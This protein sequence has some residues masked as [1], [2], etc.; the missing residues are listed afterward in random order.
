M[1]SLKGTALSETDP[2]RQGREI[3]PSLPASACRPRAAGTSG[4]CGDQRQ[5][6]CP[7]SVHRATDQ[8]PAWRTAP[9]SHGLFLFFQR[10]VISCSS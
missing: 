10:E 6:W 3:L 4:G 9:E 5:L 2:H 1:L 7:T 8:P